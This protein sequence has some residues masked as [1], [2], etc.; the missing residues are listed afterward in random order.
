MHILDFFGGQIH[1]VIWVEMTKRIF[2][3]N[4]QD[5]YILQIRCMITFTFLKELK[6]ST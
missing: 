3:F 1:E 2:G 5:Q 6:M 4:R